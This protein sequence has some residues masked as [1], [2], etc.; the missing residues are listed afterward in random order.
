MFWA[1][2]NWR[3]GIESMPALR[4]LPPNPIYVSTLAT[5][6]GI[7]TRDNPMSSIVSALSA[8]AG[9]DNWTICIQAPE[10]KPLRSEATYES[11]QNLSITGWD[12]EPWYCYGSEIITDWTL[13]SGGIYRKS[14]GW[15]TTSLA[16]VTT[17]S[18]QIGDRFFFK[19]LLHNTTTP[20]TPAE[21]EIG[22]QNGVLYIRLPNSENPNSHN[23]EVGRRNSL[24]LTRGFGTLTVRYMIG[25]YFLS[26]GLRNGASGQPPGTGKLD[27]FD[28]TIEYTSNNGIGAT[29]QN[30]LTTCTRVKC[31]RVANDGFNLHKT[32]GTGA[33]LM[34]LNGCEGSYNGDR[35]ND[36]AQ[37][38]SNHED[39]VLIINGGKYDYNVSGGMVVI[40]TARCDINGATEYGEVTMD[41]NMRLGISSGTIAAQAGCAWMESSVGIVSGS[42]IVKNGQGIGVKINT[43][44]NV[45]D[46][47]III[48]LNNAL[49]DVGR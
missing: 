45:I 1:N 42:I 43:P 26:A 44:G 10:S 9:L 6:D 39:S 11:T 8:C 41:G 3:L 20:T 46:E 18:E 13:V 49:P 4:V 33:A 15:T 47:D 48:S 38:A 2:Q 22:Y 24:L 40:N 34:I 7:G 21:G 19:K 35:F 32:T 16:V 27:V 28:T 37:G 30:E 5:I 17:M 36:S 14:L 25:R 12:N 23:I 29:G 31:Y